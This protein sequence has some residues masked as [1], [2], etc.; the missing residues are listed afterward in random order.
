LNS[1]DVESDEENRAVHALYLCFGGP[2]AAAD[3]RQ[4]ARWF[5]FLLQRGFDP[6]TAQSALRRWNPRKSDEP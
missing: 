6:E 4:I 5:W 1:P 3:P 2:P